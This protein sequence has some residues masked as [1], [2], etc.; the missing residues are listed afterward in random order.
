MKAGDLELRTATPDDAEIVADIESE[1]HPDDAA[2]PKLMRHWWT[3]DPVGETVERF[4]AYQDGAPV[5]HA[6]ARHL[7]WT[8][9][10]ER[11]ARIGA[12]LRLALRTP[13]RLGALLGA[14]EE[15]AIADGAQKVTVWSWAHDAARGELLAQRGY[16]EVR[17]QRFWE[18]D[19]AANREKIDR[20]TRESRERMRR[21]GIRVLTLAEDRDPE[22]FRKLKRMSDEAEADVPS[23]VPFVPVSHEDFMK[24][25]SSPGLRPDRIWIAREG[26]DV[27]GISMLSYPPIRG[28]V[29]TDW[30]GTARKVRGRGVARAL[31]CETVTQAIALGIDRVRTDNDS[32]NAPILH[33]NE[34]MG[35]RIRA[36]MVQ[37]LKEL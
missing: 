16:R 30:T 8:K 35:Y 11:F 37:Y 24:W 31:K 10:P 26:D 5:G 19:L 18:L 29:V 20:M 1:V 12:E 9:M 34:T 4:V 21:D 13:A 32:Q 33:I 17:R 2:D 6:F 28:P 7:P 3:L 36:E 15:R 25:F 23:T 27:V 14:M 22:K